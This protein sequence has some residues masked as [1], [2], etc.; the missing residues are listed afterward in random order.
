MRFS[1]LFTLALCI[2]FSA[3][4]CQAGGRPLLL[5]QIKVTIAKVR[6]EKTVD[7]RAN[8]AEH[9][10][11][12]TQKVRSKEVTNTLVADLTSLLDSPD[13]SVR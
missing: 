4:A 9:L 8:A 3:A 1:M 6:S 12:L 5:E 11:S 2:V 13:E 10:A 7:A